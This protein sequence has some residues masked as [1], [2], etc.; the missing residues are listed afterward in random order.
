MRAAAVI[1]VA[2]L[3]VFVAHAGLGLG[4]RGFD[5]FANNWLYDSLVG[6]AAIACIVRGLAVKADRAAWLLFG[7][8]LTFNAAAEI[9]YSFAFGENGN[10]PTPSVADVLYLSYYP[11]VYA[12]LVLLVRRQ[13]VRFNSSMWLDGAI[14]ATATAAVVAAAVVAPVAHAT[15]GDLARVAT[16]VAYPAGDLIL[17]SIVVAVFALSAWRPAGAWLLLGL[18]LVLGAIADSIY[19]YQNATESYTVGTLL[20]ASGRHRS[21]R[22]PSP[23]GVR[24]CAEKAC[25]WMECACCS[26]RRRSPRWRSGC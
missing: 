2:G 22:S 1:G 9:Y 17:L 10:P 6:G 11:C 3:A 26:V 14:A 4:G 20:D 13:L 19:A 25:A 8:G 5:S 24:R 16:V 12:G 23:R 7:A 18:A 15:H 21:S